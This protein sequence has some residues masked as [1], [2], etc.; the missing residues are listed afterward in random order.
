MFGLRCAQKQRVANKSETPGAEIQDTNS[1]NTAKCAAASDPR[2]Q[3]RGMILPIAMESLERS[4]AGIDRGGFGV[5][6]SHL[7]RSPR[8]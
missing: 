7:T 8:A 6:A 1:Q 5:V 2:G 4:E 3:G